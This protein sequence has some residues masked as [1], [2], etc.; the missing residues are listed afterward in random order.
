MQCLDILRQAARPSVSARTRN[1]SSRGAILS[2]ALIVVLMLSSAA[3]ILAQGG[4]VIGPA[5]SPNPPRRVP[6]GQVQ[7]EASVPITGHRP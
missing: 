5:S 1:P 6:P 4:G 2:I 3:M 7:P